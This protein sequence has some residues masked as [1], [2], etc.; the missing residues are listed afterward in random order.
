MRLYQRP[1]LYATL[2]GPDPEMFRRVGELVESYLE[3]ERRSVLDPACGPG[4]WL[5]LFAQQGWRLGGNDSSLP[6]VSTARVA[7]SGFSAELTHG[8]MRRLAFRT[9]PFDLAT[10]VS[11]V[12]AELPDDGAFVAH[13]RS[14]VAQ[15]RPGG[16]YLFLLPR[17]KGDPGAPACVYREGPLPAPGGGEASIGYRLVS[18]DD[19]TEV[20]WMERRVVLRAPGSAD[21]ELTDR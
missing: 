13:L 16:L 21:Q 10:E 4:D 8:D 17:W 7:L 2:R 14:V 18:Y 3:G 20:A 15:L 19:R 1:D 6:M 9:A 11:G 5:R 12:V